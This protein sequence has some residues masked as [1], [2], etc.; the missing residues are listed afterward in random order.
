MVTI[1]LFYHFL[2]SYFIA[3]RAGLRVSTVEK[4]RGAKP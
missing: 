1:Y 2:G 3:P 4:E